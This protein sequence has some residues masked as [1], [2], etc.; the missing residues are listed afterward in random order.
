MSELTEN[1][2]TT[3]GQGRFLPCAAGASLLE[4]LSRATDGREFQESACV[5]AFF[6]A[7]PFFETV[8]KNGEKLCAKVKSISRGVPGG[9]PNGD[10]NFDR[11]VMHTEN[12]KTNLPRR[13]LRENAV[14]KT[15][16]TNLKTKGRE[17]RQPNE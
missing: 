6:R 16:N 13:F 10:D 7:S 4:H 5:R 14:A 17:S 8:K 15:F 2:M 9:D 12:Q 3:F 1:S 11:M